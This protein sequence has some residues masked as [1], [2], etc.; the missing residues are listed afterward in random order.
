MTIISFC[1]NVF[2]SLL[3][4]IC[5][6]MSASGK[7]LRIWYLP[8]NNFLNSQ[9]IVLHMLLDFFHIF[10]RF[11]GCA[12]KPSQVVLQLN[13]VIQNDLYNNL[14]Q[15]TTNLQQIMSNFSFCQNLFSS[16]LLLI[17]KNVPAFD[18]WLSI[19]ELS[20]QISIIFR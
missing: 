13:V 17:N 4:Q 9:S 11:P 5:L 6:I 2:K 8:R 14:F 7:Y 10:H 12:F 20:S 15:H 18:M 1:R 19:R 3:I 16:C